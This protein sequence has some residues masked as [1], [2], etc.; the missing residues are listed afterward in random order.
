MGHRLHCSKTHRG[1]EE[2]FKTLQGKKADA[3]LWS[4]SSLARG[5]FE[6]S[7]FDPR[8]FGVVQ[9]FPHG[10]LLSGDQI[11]TKIIQ[12]L[13]FLSFIKVIF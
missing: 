10:N 1:K 5:V 13:Y 11:N 8:S 7:F 3:E 6:P 4:L 9:P 2:D 12:K